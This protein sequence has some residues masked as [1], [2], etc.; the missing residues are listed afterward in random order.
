MEAIDRRDSD[1][2]NDELDDDFVV[3]L[4][5]YQAW[6]GTCRSTTASG[7]TI[8]RGHWVC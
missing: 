7:V 6:P 5:R 8:A 3:A 4:A 1:T 2:V